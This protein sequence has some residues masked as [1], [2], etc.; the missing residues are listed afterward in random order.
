[1]EAPLETAK[2]AEVNG[3]E[4]SSI[5]TD[6]IPESVSVEGSNRAVTSSLAA[7]KA[8][9]FVLIV[10]LDSPTLSDP[11]IVVIGTLISIEI[12][13]SLLLIYHF[14]QLSHRY[15]ATPPLPPLA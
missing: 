14:C 10:S 1:M 12:F 5:V 11:W 6:L 4:V 9:K 2:I 15:E 3:K 7:F 13:Y 8:A